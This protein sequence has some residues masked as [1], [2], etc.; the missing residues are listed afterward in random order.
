MNDSY[1]SAA[2]EIAQE[3]GKILIE[4]LSCP[5]DIRYKG[6]EVDLVTQA[7]KRSERLI[8]E[9]LSKYFPDHA[10]T[11]E[12]GTGH[13][14]V[15]ASDFRWH[16]EEAGGKISDFYGNPFQLGCPVILASNGLIHEEMRTMAIEIYRRGKQPRESRNL[17]IRGG[18]QPFS[19]WVYH[20]N[21]NEKFQ[22]PG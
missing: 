1:L 6:D 14:S 22:S 21:C 3:A 9:R 12:E 2:I 13:E 17:L 15:S 10:I 11:A 7:D 18:C 20:G 19:N 5:L 16:V 4:E 8:V